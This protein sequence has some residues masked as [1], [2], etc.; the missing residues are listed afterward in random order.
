MVKKF[1]GESQMMNFSK[2]KMN[3][4]DSFRKGDIIASYRW[5]DHQDHGYT[6]LRAFHKDYRPGP[7]N[8]EHNRQKNSFTKIWY[9]RSAREI[10]KFVERFYKDHTCCYGV[11]PRPAIL[12]SQKGHPRGAR[13]SDITT[14]MNFYLDIDFEKEAVNREDFLELRDIIE[15]IDFY[16]KKLKT[17]PPVR[18]FTGNGYHLLF[19]LPPVSVSEFP[20]IKEKLNLFRHEIQYEFS[21]AMKRI[22]ARKD[23]TMDL[24]KVAKIYGTKKPQGKHCSRFFGKERVEDKV[25][26]EYL[27]SLE[28]E[29]RPVGT[30]PVLDELP[31]S[32][33]KLLSSD[34]TLRMLWEGVGKT[35]GDTT[36]SGYDFSLVKECMQKKIT[37][38]MEL[39]TILKLRPEG[40]VQKGGKGD[41]Y[42]RLTIA[43]AIK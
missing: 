15:D 18:A 29:E 25:L 4:Q 12:R 41:S 1:I 38:V 43:N 37:D 6:E 26:L 32:F 35:D 9:V 8:F 23:N 14:V 22:G 36:R 33:K 11:D 39:T 24:S 13:E 28:P 2:T 3:P 42:V 30:I 20:D 7:E 10:L 19:A 40:A 31:E 17:T 27:R 21:D 34:E 5:L 16:L